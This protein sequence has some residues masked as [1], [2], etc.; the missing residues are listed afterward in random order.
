MA[1]QPPDNSEYRKG[2]QKRADEHVVKGLANRG[3]RPA[4]LAGL[5]G[6]PRDLP[7]IL[8]LSKAAET[9]HRKIADMAAGIVAAMDEH[10][11]HVEANLK[12]LR[13]MLSTTDLNNQR[14]R[15]ISERRAE[16]LGIGIADRDKIMAELAAN[17]ALLETVRSEY[18]SS[19]SYL[20]TRTL[21]GKAGEKRA[22]YLALLTTSGEQETKAAVREAVATSNEPLL[23]AAFSRIDALIAADHGARERLGVNKAEVADILVRPSR[24]AAL[25]AIEA[26]TLAR[27]RAALALRTAEGVP[28]TSLEKIGFGARQKLLDSWIEEIS[29][30]DDP[31]NPAPAGMTDIER[32]ING[33][34]VRI[35]E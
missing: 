18:E 12:P 17:V 9:A 10:A 28:P 8:K 22:A 31:A 19:V 24:V 27:D 13:S 4:S 7:A 14:R 5:Q 21:S 1:A 23:A 25:A 15:Q 6:T 30:P 2:L 29:P 26:G 3:S 34:P 20:M 33:L 16:L 32:L 11:E 35:I